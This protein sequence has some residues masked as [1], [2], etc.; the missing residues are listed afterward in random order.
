M[1]AAKEAGTGRGI[2]GWLAA[3]CVLAS[4]L[5]WAV[6]DFLR[7]RLELLEEGGR[8][9]R[10]LHGAWILLSVLAAAGFIFL[11]L[12][13][14]RITA[15]RVRWGLYSVLFAL[16]LATLAK[17]SILSPDKEEVH[18]ALFHTL[19]LLYL[20]LWTTSLLLVRADQGAR[21]RG[22]LLVLDIVLMNALVLLLVGEMALSLLSRISPSPLFLG[23][24]VERNL[25]AL[26]YAPGTRYFDFYLNSRGYHDEE[27]FEAEDTDLLVAVVGD[28]F[29][30]GIVPYEFNFVS[31]LEKELQAAR[32]EGHRRVAVD[33]FGVPGI[34]MF[35]YAH[36]METEILPLH[37]SL[38][39]VAV[40][41]GNDILE[42]KPPRRRR[43]TLDDWLVVTVPRRILAVLRGSS[44]GGVEA[45]AIGRRAQD[46]RGTPPYIHDP[47]LEIPTFPEEEFCRI[48]RS[49]IQVLDPDDPVT[50][51][52]MEGF[53]ELLDSMQERLGERLLVL[54][55]PDE[56]QVNDSLRAEILA[57]HP[58]PPSRIELRYPQDR[59]AAWAREKGARVVD[60]LDP[61][62]E[63]WS[64]QRV[65]HLRDTHINAAGN[66]VV[67]EALL[68]AV[69]ER[70]AAL[71]GG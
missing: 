32:G 42:S 66:A 2:G 63:A 5:V 26:R 1:A 21:K 35:E 65:Y 51:R 45:A 50:V 28:S 61:L 13:R 43:F 53:L 58:A 14:R 37:P 68:P 69:L 70:V 16:I 20:V 62:R 41:V 19:L 3:L 15:A 33:N 30:V 4:A 38:V 54:V 47:S 60:V 9:S 25:E 8:S 7:H 71:E 57:R 23:A 10:I 48:E 6:S 55:L 18:R 22:A 40:F 59:I 56:F 17:L 52:R 11:A 67:A 46:Q 27:F 36:L 29:T 49:R 31:I 64:R 44:P 24:S 12:R 39:V 34:G